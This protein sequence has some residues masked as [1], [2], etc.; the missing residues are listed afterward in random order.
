MA[1]EAG[2]KGGVVPPEL[3]EKID[4]IEDKLDHSVHGLAALKVLIDLLEGKLDNPLYGLQALLNLLLALTRVQH[5]TQATT[6]VLTTIGTEIVSATPFRVSG[7]LSLHNMVA[8]DA[9]LIIEEIRDQDDATYR[10]YGGPTYVGAQGSP[11]I[12]FPE[13][14]CQGWRVR[15]QRAAGANRNVTYQ[16][17]VQ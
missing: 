6:N 17:F 13:K 4:D 11:M 8:G 3:L 2:S 15:I 12:W 1:Q 16:F 14:A 5:G 9:F 10:Q 7:L